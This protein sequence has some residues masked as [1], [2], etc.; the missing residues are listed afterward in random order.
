MHLIRN[1]HKDEIKQ[2]IVKSMC[3]LANSIGSYIIAEGIESEHELQ[4]LIDLDVHYGQGYYLQKPAEKL[5]PLKDEI[6]KKIINFNI[7]NSNRPSYTIST[8][9]TPS[10][11]ITSNILV[12]KVDEEFKKKY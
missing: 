12:S 9:S 1:I 2:A 10:K 11:T 5:F 7:I 8:L 6:Y 4:K 3:Q